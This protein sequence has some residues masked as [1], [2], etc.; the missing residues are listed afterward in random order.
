MTGI[1]TGRRGWI[2]TRRILWSNVRLG[3]GDSGSFSG[4]IALFQPKIIVVGLEF[5]L[6]RFKQDPGRGGIN[7]DIGIT[8]CLGRLTVTVGRHDAN[9]NFWD[10]SAVQGSGN[11]IMDRYRGTGRV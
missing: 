9:N 10:A 4:S 2:S 8:N 1:I 11:K 3:C 6:S 7:M 5:L